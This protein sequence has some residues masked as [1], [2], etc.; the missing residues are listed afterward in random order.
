MITCH[1]SRAM[2]DILKYNHFAQLYYIPVLTNF[3][4]NIIV[5]KELQ[6][7]KISMIENKKIKL[8]KKAKEAN[9]NC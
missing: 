7:L 9:A 2:Y 1:I 4:L 5:L 6:R 8:R 3:T